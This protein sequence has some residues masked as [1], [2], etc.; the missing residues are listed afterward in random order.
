MLKIP[1]DVD[2]YNLVGTKLHEGGN[3]KTVVLGDSPVYLVTKLMPA[4]DLARSQILR[5]GRQ[6]QALP[7]PTFMGF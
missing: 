7:P 1:R 6:P 5:V 3:G 2:A 4:G